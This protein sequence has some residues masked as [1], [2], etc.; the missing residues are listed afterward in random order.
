MQLTVNTMKQAS[1]Y[2]LLCVLVSIGLSSCHKDIQEKGE[3]TTTPITQIDVKDLTQSDIVGYIYD[4]TDT[5]MADVEVSILG[6]STRTNEFGVFVFRNTDLD[7]N[8]TYIKAT[9]SGYI[10]GSDRIYPDKADVN[11][12]YLKMMR[13]TSTTTVNGA[14]GGNIVV[15][16]GGIITFGANTIVNSDGSPFSGTVTVTAKRIAADDPDLADVMPGGLLAEDKEEYTRVLGTLG[17]VAVELRDPNGNELNLADGSE[18][19]VQFPI[20]QGQLS[21]A[22]D[23]IALW[24]FDETKGLW[25]EEGFATRQGDNYVGQVSH[26]SFWNCDAPFPLIHVCGT[27]LNADGTPAENISVEVLVDVQFPSGY[28]VTDSEGRFCGKMPKGKELTITIFHPGCQQEGFTFTVGPFDTDT[29]LDPVSLSNVNNGLITGQVLC[30]GAPVPNASVVVL[31]DQQTLVYLADATGNYSFNTSIFGCE[32]IGTS[33]IFAID[34]DS[35]ESSSAQTFDLNQDASIDLHT[36]GGCDMTIGT[37]IGTDDVCDIE[38]YYATVDVSG[39]N[40]NVTYSWGNG[41]TAQTNSN[42]SIGINCVTVTDSD[43]CEEIS[44]IDFEF[45]GLADSLAVVNSSCEMNNG[46]IKSNPFN[47]TPPYNYEIS[48]PGGFVSTEM[49]VTDLLP[50]LYTV[51]V[52]DD[53][54]C[55]TLNTQEVIEVG[56]IPDFEIYEEC[57]VTQLSIPSNLGEFNINFNGND[58]LNI[59]EIFQSG[60]YCFEITNSQGCLETRCIDVLVQGEFPF[61]VSVSC[62]FPNYRLDWQQ[63]AFF[64]TYSSQDSIN[65]TIDSQ[66][67]F[68]MLISPLELG[69]SGILTLEDDVGLCPYSEFINLPKYEGLEA[70]GVSPSCDD[71]EDGYIEVAMDPDAG[72][73]DCLLGE[74]AIYDKDSDPLLENDLSG[75]NSEQLLPAGNYYVVVTDQDSGCIISHRV[76][77]L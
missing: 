56:G 68:S 74:L 29:E 71:C 4:E 58:F 37:S 46:S 33:S 50:G 19:T 65:K 30:D 73:F 57:G 44:C 26:F 11:H 52:T 70:T 28:G 18:A 41:N 77:T 76:I 64:A 20:A 53:N 38:A 17:M 49:E 13:L 7:A 67:E 15:Q 40:G 51:L 42:I 66:F 24:S 55:S 12:S 22:P 2:L 3:T 1:H 6:N 32:T 36:C 5:P 23:Q 25:I 63:T 54:G 61:F 60:N 34:N 16:G 45:L 8:G 39:G 31:I 69:Y 21:E 14:N 9:K 47:G 75:T 48:G 10:L 72:C 27:V 62:E 43:G 59:V 35:N